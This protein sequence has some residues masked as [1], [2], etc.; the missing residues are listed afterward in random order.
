MPLPLPRPSPRGLSPDNFTPPSRTPWGGRRIRAHYKAGLP[1]SAGDPVVGES[2][3][4]SVEPSFPSRV[5]ET[6][7]LLSELIARNPEGWLGKSSARHQGQTPLLVK[8]IDTADRLS[9]QVHPRDDDPAL[10]PDESGKP[11]AWIV[12][13]ADEGAGIYLGFA[14]GVGR[15]EVARCL[16]GG[17]ALDQLM[18]FVPVAAGDAFVIAAGTPHAIGAG[19]TL[20]EPQ[21]VRPGRRGLTYRFWDWNRRYDRQ[22]RPAA[23]GAPRELHVARSLAVTRWEA[24]RGEA[25]VDSCRAEPRELQ[26]AAG[27]DGVL[28]G[29]RVIDWPWFV[30]D[31]WRGTGK[32][33]W[34]AEGT[35]LAVT[36]TAGS[37]VVE[38]DTGVLALRRGESGVVPA[39]ARAL[40]LEARDGDAFVVRVRE[41]PEA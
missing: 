16:E 27:D 12:L 9:V 17:G 25:F 22:G 18:T 20:I 1:L 21:F 10:G 28:Q 13:E 34:L 31:R 23:L 8:L 39:C 41:A 19:I 24:P 35:M 2:W 15:D 32:A 36:C 38:G 3:E 6:D 33:A 5:G 7:E 11:E 26:V 29:D 40:E 14:D 30:V 37:V 4:V